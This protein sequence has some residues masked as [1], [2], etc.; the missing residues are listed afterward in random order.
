MVGAEFRQGLQAVRLAVGA[1]LASPVRLAAR[2]LVAVRAVAVG[3]GLA[4]V[5]LVGLFAGPVGAQ[6]TLERTPSLDGTWVSDRGVA[7]FHLIHRFWMTD[8]P[9]E[10]VINTPTITL[11]A[12][13]GGGVLVG[14]RYASNS[15]LVAT[16]NVWEAFGRWRPLTQASTGVVDLAVGAGW[17]A[18][19]ESVDGEVAVAR[20]IGPV[21]LLATARAFSAFGA[22]DDFEAAY[23]GGA[24]W[25]LHRNIALAGDV[26]TLASDT[27]VGWGVGLQ[28]R[29]PTTPHTVSLH[30]TNV[31]TM[32]LQGSSFGSGFIDSETGDPRT[33]YGFEFTVPVTFSRDFG[34]AGEPEPAPALGPGEG[35]APSDTAVV[36]MDNRLRFLPDTVR[37]AAGQAVRWEN[38]S[39]L[40][41][42]VTADPA[43]AALDSS[44]RL[45]EGAA[46]FDSGDIAPGAAYVRV[47]DRPG[48]YKYFCVPH[49]RAGMVGWVIVASGS[50]APAE[51]GSQ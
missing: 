26:M 24:V 19:A 12:G 40:I 30:A 43:R 21:R 51:G 17:N 28:L 15:L 50:D 10:K 6:S 39:D 7:H 46:T 4:G 44:V 25:R 20:S 38:T 35:P 8:P 9:A 2:Q 22:G 34:A 3:A 11:A 31:N 18:G 14:A 41:H 13:L 45:P 1:R 16:P 49:E 27:T 32:T 48:V 47:F 23:G 29:I 36:G 42:T 5:L 33:L 37:V